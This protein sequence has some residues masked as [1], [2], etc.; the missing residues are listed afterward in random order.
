[1]FRKKQEQ[2]PTHWQLP[3]YDGT[4]SY[5]NLLVGV[6]GVTWNSDWLNWNKSNIDV[7]LQRNPINIIRS[8]R[9]SSSLIQFGTLGGY[10]WQSIAAANNAAGNLAF[11]E[12][13]LFPEMAYSKDY[14]MTLRCLSASI[15][16]K[17]RS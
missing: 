11:Y 1:M 9:Y 13:Y 8:G 14:G 3:T 10:Y 5:Q 12:Y 15:S 4:K 7:A 2:K 16:T 6:Y 17:N